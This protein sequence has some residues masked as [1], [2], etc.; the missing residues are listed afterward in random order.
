[1]IV[2]NGQFIEESQFTFNQGHSTSN[3]GLLYGDGLFETMRVESG[4]IILLEEHVER[5]SGSLRT[6]GYLSFPSKVTFCEA[7]ANLVL[8]NGVTHG[9]VRLT[10]V[11]APADFSTPLQMIQGANWWVVAKEA[12]INRDLYRTGVVVGMSQHQRRNRHSV[13]SKHKTTSYLENVMAKQEARDRKLFEILLCNTDGYL[14]EG[15]TTNVFMVSKEGRVLTPKLDGSLLPGVTRRWVL[16]ALSA[17]KIPC[18]EALILPEALNDAKE[19]F[20]TNATYGILP[21]L[22]METS[23]YLV[24]E[25][26]VSHKL[27]THYCD[28]FRIT[29]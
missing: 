5:I 21:V 22:Q 8:K 23:T 13:L 19:V 29:M 2:F 4:R 16:G 27:W 7:I 9:Y 1:M 18:E 20:L 24:G 17:L 12:H 3:R 10:V 14:S 6:L 28:L 25:P 11:R 15:A 26:S